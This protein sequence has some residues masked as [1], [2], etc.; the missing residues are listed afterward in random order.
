MQYAEGNVGLAFGLVVGAGIATCVGSCLVFCTT[1]ANSRMLAGCLGL[2]AGVM[3]YVSFAEIFCAKSVAAFE[4]HYADDANSAGKA[5]RMATFCFF[6][7]MACMAALNA[8]VHLLEGLANPSTP[9]CSEAPVSPDTETGS[10][11]TLSSSTEN[12]KNHEGAGN[13]SGHGSVVVSIASDTYFSDPQISR[14]VEKV[15]SESPTG[16][17]DLVVPDSVKEIM[18]RD[19]HHAGL[20][21]MGIARYVI[22]STPVPLSFSWNCRLSCDNAK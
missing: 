20:N 19:N 5:L 15:D 17:N 1:L 22:L 14:D 12:D 2:S 7:G 6:A 18:E 10:D 11:D 8:V 16:G 9:L 13:P 21:K 3:L 4:E